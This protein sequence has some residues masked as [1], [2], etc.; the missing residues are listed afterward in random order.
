MPAESNGNKMSVRFWGV[1]G[2][3]P[4]PQAENL[5]FGGNTSCVE[6]TTPTGDTL[7][8]DAGSGIRGIGQRLMQEA[9]GKPIHANIFLT[10]FHWDHIQGLPFFAP[11]YGS[12]NS[13]AFH[14][15]RTGLP[16]QE[17]L[18]GQMSQPYFPVDLSQV[19]AHRTF[20]QFGQDELITIGSAEIRPFS[21][22][23]PNGASGYRI[24]CGKSVVVYATDFE[25][26]HLDLD[27][28][29]FDHVRDADVLI[30]D[31]Q[32]TPQEYESHKG[33]GHSTWRHAA[34]IAGKVGVKQLVLFH[35]EPGHDDHTMARIQTEARVEFPNT[36]AAW[37]GLTA[38]L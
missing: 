5:K 27:P 30:C 2:S 3:T 21:L 17:T 18:E 36:A 9:A 35:H 20:S 11:L 28:V 13:V 12:K 4:T 19:A 16:L 6:I 7:I 14:S 24:E 23:H 22:N 29:L 25:H 33:W 10:H 32:Y 1:R 31:T 37:E 15:G 26:G 8:F 38:T 34:G